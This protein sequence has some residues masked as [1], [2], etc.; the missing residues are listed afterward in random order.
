M[1]LETIH[2]FSVYLFF[3]GFW[4]VGEKKIEVVRIPQIMWRCHT[5]LKYWNGL[6]N[7]ANRFTYLTADIRQD[8]HIFE[9]CLN[10]FI[11]PW[12]VDFKF[13][14]FLQFKTEIALFSYLIHTLIKSLFYFSK[15]IRGT[16]HKY[17]VNNK[18][19]DK[20][21]W[22]DNMLKEFCGNCKTI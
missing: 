8:T 18:R 14:C 2:S 10:C 4:L 3:I 9:F 21:H 11:T 20:S 6:N 7:A 1:L 16:N 13:K 12:K 17:L 5:A 19:E 22:N 15:K